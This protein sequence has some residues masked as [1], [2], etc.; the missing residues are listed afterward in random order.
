MSVFKDLTGQRFGSLNVLGRSEKRQNGRPTYTVQCDCGVVKVVFGKYLS[1]GDTK[2]CGCL[3]NRVLKARNTTHDKTF[4]KEYKTWLGVKQRCLDKNHSN[5][6]KYGAKGITIFEEWINDF[7]SF[8]S[9]IGKAPTENHTIERLNNNLG[10]VPNNVRWAT[11]L[12]QARNRSKQKNNKTG[13]TGVG[14]D[15][16]RYFAAWKVNGANKTKSFSISKFGE[17]LAFFAASMYRE[18]QIDKLRLIGVNYS[19][20]HGR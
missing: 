10:Y 14:K 3:L 4:T 17:E 6:I 8:L 2:S 9:H 5:Y 19:E 13:I 18:Q 15:N 20:N 12:E 16:K 7:D 1:N 11:Q